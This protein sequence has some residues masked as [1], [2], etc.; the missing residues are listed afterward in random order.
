MGWPAFYRNVVSPLLEGAAEQ[1]SLTAT[2][3][4][5]KA[6]A[7]DNYHQDLN[8][9]TVGGILVTFSLLRLTVVARLETG[10]FP[11]WSM[12]LFLVYFVVAM[13]IVLL[14]RFSNA[15]EYLNTRSQAVNPIY[16]L[17]P[18]GRVWIPGPSVRRI[19]WSRLIFSSVSL[20][21]RTA[22]GMQFVFDVAIFS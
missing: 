9:V 21:I 2:G 16:G 12:L 19:F 1:L 14:H 22:T 7:L 4:V 6:F 3:H 18:F 11:D 17:P 5:E 15:K 10:S 13:W 20:V 8:L